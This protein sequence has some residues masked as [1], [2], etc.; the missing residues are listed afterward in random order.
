[1][2]T[3][4]NGLLLPFLNRTSS[5]RYVIGCMKETTTSRH[6]LPNAE[7]ASD[8]VAERSLSVSHAHHSGAI[9]SIIKMTGKGEIQPNLVY[10]DPR[11]LRSSRLATIESMHGIRLDRE[12]YREVNIRSKNVWLLFS[13]FFNFKFKFPYGGWTDEPLSLQPSTGRLYSVSTVCNTHTLTDD[14]NRCRVI[15]MSYLL[16]VLIWRGLR[17]T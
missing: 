12:G 14:L 8:G 9:D 13:F 4:S 16:P 5:S 7:H 2:R 3:T 15:Q 11:M 6:S 17:Y 1:M 10:S